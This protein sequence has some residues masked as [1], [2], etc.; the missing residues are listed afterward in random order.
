MNHPAFCIRIAEF[1]LICCSYMCA[2]MPAVSPWT[3]WS[4]RCSALTFEGDCVRIALKKSIIFFHIVII[5][6]TNHKTKEQK[7]YRVEW[8]RFYQVQTMHKNK[9]EMVRPMRKYQNQVHPV[10]QDTLCVNIHWD[11]IPDRWFV[12]RQRADKYTED[13]EDF[14][15]L[16]GIEHFQEQ[17]G[18][19]FHSPLLQ[20]CAAI[21]STIEYPSCPFP[22][23]RNNQ[24]ARL[25]ESRQSVITNA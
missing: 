9:T 7:Y 19:R 24:P 17:M 15:W 1:S 3:Q 20:L 14:L 16:S 12:V 2:A 4:S 10:A 18:P 8:S 11:N 23:H 5:P 25:P 6:S 21:H 13:A 22:E